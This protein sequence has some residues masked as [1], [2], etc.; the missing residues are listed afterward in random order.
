MSTPPRSPTLLSSAL[1]NDLCRRSTRL[2]KAHNRGWKDVTTDA[3]EFAPIHRMIHSGEVS[4]PVLQM[5]QADEMGEMSAAETLFAVAPTK[6]W[7]ILFDKFN[8]RLLQAQR[9]SKD[10][11]GW[12]FE[13]MCCLREHSLSMEKTISNQKR[14]SELKKQNPRLLWLYVV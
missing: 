8:D 4:R 6:V 7:R 12:S 5:L 14:M 3:S 13:L 2:M 1:R 10:K 11:K 9:T